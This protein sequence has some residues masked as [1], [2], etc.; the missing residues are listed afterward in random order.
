MLAQDN[1]RLLELQREKKSNSAQ[2][3]SVLRRPMTLPR[4]LWFSLP[5]LPYMAAIGL[6]LLR[7]PD[8]VAIATEAQS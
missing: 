2:L 6:A 1:H 4:R 8:D 5:G 3:C 7:L